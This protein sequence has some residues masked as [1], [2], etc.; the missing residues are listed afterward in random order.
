VPALSVRSNIPKLYLIYVLAWFGFIAPIIILFYQANGLTLRDA[1][2]LQS[3]F[4][5]AVLALEIPSGYIS[6]RWGRKQTT[7]TG[8]L[9]LFLG[10]LT[11]GFSTSFAG[12]FLAEMLLAVGVSFHS[13]TL[14]A[15]TYD[16][17]LELKREGSYKHLYGRQIS[18]RFLAEAL[19]SLCAGFL[20]VISFRVPFW[21]GAFLAGISFLVAL[22]LIEPKRHKL[23]EE[24]HLQ[25]IWK[26]SKQTLKENIPLRSIII[27][28]S[29]IGV[30]TLSLFWFTQP[31]QIEMGLPVVFFGFVHAGIVIMGA[32][33]TRCTHAISQ[34][35]SDR[36][37]LTLIAVSVLVSYAL[38]SGITALW[39][40]AFFA[41]GRIAWGFLTPLISDIVNRMTASDTRATVLSV[42]MFFSR[43][44]F[45]IFA[46]FWGY[47]ADVYSLQTAILTAGCIGAVAIAVTL[48]AMKGVWKSI[49]Q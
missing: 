31:Y 32:I 23:Q 9:F 11:Y 13:G 15:L 14:E 1:F 43:V 48:V 24:R 6:D 49:P 28:S 35:I 39:A 40:I 22:T 7:I 19:G 36:L 5:I 10:F 4:S 12:F 26:I 34:R 16:T 17:L 18:F 8:S 20:M 41:V 30:L 3:L 33:A 21:T 45:A 42:R 38:L 2:L 46:P 29:L 27:L 44:L 25:A 37:F 47:L